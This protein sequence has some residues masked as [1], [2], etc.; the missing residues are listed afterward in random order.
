MSGQSISITALER[1]RLGLE[2]KPVAAKTVASWRGHGA[3]LS[4]QASVDVPEEVGS[5]DQIAVIYSVVLRNH[6]SW[7]EKLHG[8]PN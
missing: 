3:E 1:P 6:G 5:Q 7:M 4:D 2:I 8:A